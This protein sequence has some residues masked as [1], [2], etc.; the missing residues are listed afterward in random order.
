[1]GSRD[2]P[3]EPPAAPVAVA[4][5]PPPVR[6]PEV[7]ADEESWGAIWSAFQ[8]SGKPKGKAYAHLF[9][10]GSQSHPSFDFGTLAYQGTLALLPG[11]QGEGRDHLLWAASLLQGWGCATRYLGD[12]ISH[13]QFQLDGAGVEIHVDRQDAQCDLR[14]WWE[15][16][17]A[18]HGRASPSPSSCRSSSWPP[19]WGQLW[20]SF[21]Q[22]QTS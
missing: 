5:P 11:V 18:L 4:I 1:M 13:H 19:H 2:K 14:S 8:R 17:R 15:H 21:G 9:S 22:Y 6:G 7:I 3:P 16:L 20:F 10:Q 12:P